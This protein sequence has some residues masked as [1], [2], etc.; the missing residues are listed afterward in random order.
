MFVLLCDIYLLVIEWA[1]VNPKSLH[2]IA[3]M[4][5]KLFPL[6]H[7]TLSNPVEIVL[8]CGIATMLAYELA[9]SRTSTYHCHFYG[10]PFSM[11]LAQ[12]TL[13]N[14]QD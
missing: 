2:R 5:Q 3:E 11:R 14:Q 6:L 12:D 7:A 4:S 10:E 9:A 1:A 13:P 8:I